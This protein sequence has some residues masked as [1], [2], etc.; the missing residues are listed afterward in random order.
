MADGLEQIG[1]L[2]VAVVVDVHVYHQRRFPGELQ[3]A[4]Q[5]Q[6]LLLR[7]VARPVQYAQMDAVPS[8]RASA[9]ETTASNT[10]EGTTSLHT[11]CYEYH[12]MYPSII[13]SKLTF[14]ARGGA[15]NPGGLF[16]RPTSSNSILSQRQRLSPSYL[17][18]SCHVQHDQPFTRGM[19]E[20]AL[21]GQNLVLNDGTP[22]NN[23]KS[24]ECHYHCAK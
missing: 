14:S 9:N 17:R 24:S 18:G 4:F 12:T 22:S 1:A 13:F 5:G 10:L 19:I 2:H 8:A 20:L 23:A 15:F 6:L 3:Q 21:R 16:P 7:A 11:A